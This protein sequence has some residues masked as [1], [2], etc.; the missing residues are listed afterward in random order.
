[1]TSPSIT[2]P[3]LR[4]RTGN[5][6]PYSTIEGVRSLAQEFD[7]E[8]RLLV[9]APAGYWVTRTG[10]TLSWLQDISIA[11]AEAVVFTWMCELTRRYCR[12]RD[13]ALLAGLGLLLLVANPWI[14]WSIPFDVHQEPLIGIVFAALFCRYLSRGRRRAWFWIIPVF[15]SGA[16]ECDLRHRTR[17]RRRAS[18]WPVTSHGRWASRRSG[19]PEL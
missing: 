6:D 17:P 11:A 2:R 12:E 10:L 8:F 1:M 4:S 14:W 3:G 19:S 9:L 16:G 15:L 13:A 7:S 5:L 18:R